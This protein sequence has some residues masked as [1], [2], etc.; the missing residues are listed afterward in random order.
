[1]VGDGVEGS[2]GNCGGHKVKFYLERAMLSTGA[3]D[4]HG[5][6]AITGR[7]VI[8]YNLRLFAIGIRQPGTSP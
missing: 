2:E 6:E 4:P 7:L 8:G 1:M 3:S 5:V